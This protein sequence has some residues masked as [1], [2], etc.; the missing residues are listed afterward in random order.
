MKKVE[1][2][3]FIHCC[4]G[5]KKKVKKVLCRMEGVYKTELDALEPK[6]TVLGNVEPQALI[7]KLLK[8]GK[9]AEIW[10]Y[11]NQVP[12]EGEKD[13]KSLLVENQKEKTKPDTKQTKEAEAQATCTD[14]LVCIEVDKEGR[15]NTAWNK[16]T[17]CKANDS[18]TG[19]TKPESSIS[20]KSEAICT[21]N[22]SIIHDSGK[23]VTE[24]NRQYYYMVEP[25]PIILPYCT[26]YPYS[27][28]LYD[29]RVACQP[30]YQAPITRAG[31]YFS[32]ENSVG[33]QIM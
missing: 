19:L 25:R 5:C 13:V 1:L 14:K 23:L 2:K 31:D 12:R 27:Q 26:M 3:V 33:C 7:K 18:S 22:P 8:S 29:G 20:Q 32:D 9:H 10:N 15:D 6:V 11:N 24:T 17:D 16:N 21:S 28:E 4:D 30:L